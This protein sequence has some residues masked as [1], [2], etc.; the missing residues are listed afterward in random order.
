MRFITIG[1]ETKRRFVVMVSLVFLL[2]IM[3]WTSP[4]DHQPVSPVIG[5][6]EPVD[7]VDITGEMIALTFNTAWGEDTFV[8]VLDALAESE[9]RATFFVSGP[10]AKTNQ[11]LLVRAREDGHEIGSLGYRQ[12]D[13]TTVD[14]EAMQEEIQRGASA[15]EGVLGDAPRLFRPPTGQWDNRVISQATE[16]GLVSVTA[17]LDARDWT[18]PGVEEIV[19]NVISE[20]ESGFII[21]F[22]A[23]DSSTQLP[24]ALPQIIS[25]L[26][27]AGFELVTVSRLLGTDDITD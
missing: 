25:Q 4:E 19:D 3:H 18:N 22:H 26:Q 5:A 1:P 10:W 17:S 27:E 11:E 12:L 14:P 15:I 16:L 23:D 6:Q 8:Q 24:E 7:R 9:T 20:A 21:E 2:L 13:L